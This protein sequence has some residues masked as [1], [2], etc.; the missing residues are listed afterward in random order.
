MFAFAAAWLAW[1]VVLPQTRVNQNTELERRRRRAAALGA[2]LLLMM[3]DLG[4]YAQACGKLSAR[5][6]T[7]RTAG[8]ELNEIGPFTVPALPRPSQTGC[9]K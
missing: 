8:K 2:V 7:A 6:Y 9:S 3:V 4:N 1:V 5:I